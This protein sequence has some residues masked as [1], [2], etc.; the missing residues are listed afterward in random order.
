M[1]PKKVWV[2][3]NYAINVQI[4]FRTKKEA[5]QFQKDMMHRSYYR[6][7]KVDNYINKFSN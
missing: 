2:A 7:R 6:V 3:E 4:K 1:T 5:M